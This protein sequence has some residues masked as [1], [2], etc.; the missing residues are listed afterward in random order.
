MCWI[1]SVKQSRFFDLVWSFHRWF[2]CLRWNTSRSKASTWVRPLL[3]HL[4]ANTLWF[5]RQPN[6]GGTPK[7]YTPTSKSI[8]IRFLLFSHLSSF[9]RVPGP[10][11]RASDRR[12]A[13]TSGRRGAD[14]RATRRGGRGRLH[15]AGGALRLGPWAAPSGAGRGTRTEAGREPRGWRERGAIGKGECV[16]LYLHIGLP[17][18]FVWIYI[19]ICR[20]VC[21]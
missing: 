2:L 1:V 12:R 6:P 11:P 18:S 17:I 16:C 9:S 19:Y 20:C 14:I 8:P 21:I 10:I 5:E 7:N 13:P 4:Q 15:A 3:G